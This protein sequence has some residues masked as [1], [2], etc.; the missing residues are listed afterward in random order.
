MAKSSPE[1][2]VTHH[3]KRDFLTETIAWAKV[4]WQENK[5]PFLDS[6]YWDPPQQYQWKNPA[7]KTPT[8]L[9]IYEVRPFPL[10]KIY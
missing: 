4:C 7:P 10:L 1:F 5:N 3:H 8:D 9:R 2:Q 6:V